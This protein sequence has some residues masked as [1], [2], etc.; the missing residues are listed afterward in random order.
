MGAMTHNVHQARVNICKKTKQK[1]NHLLC[2]KCR[3]TARNC[4]EFAQTVVIFTDA[5]SE[6]SKLEQKQNLLNSL[7]AEH[8][9]FIRSV[10]KKKKIWTGGLSSAWLLA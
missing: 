5:A 4:L 3:A 8:A 7:M 2:A 6:E 1:N 9:H 10:K